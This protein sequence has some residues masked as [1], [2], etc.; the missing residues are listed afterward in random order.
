MVAEN[1]CF[2]ADASSGNVSCDLPIVLM[3]MF[4]HRTRQVATFT[5]GRTPQSDDAFV[6]ACEISM[7]AE[8]RRVALIVR[9]VIA[10]EGSVDPK[11]IYATDRYPED[12][13]ILPSWDS[14]DWVDFIVR[15]EKHLEVKIPNRD[16]EKLYLNRFTVKQMV[17]RIVAYCI[18]R[19]AARSKE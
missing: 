18:E 15:L 17:H 7:D 9:E 13:E 19:Q 16:A 11:F 4:Q 5:Q 1:N 8:A 14:L 3:R 10:R 12:L 2:V 6:T